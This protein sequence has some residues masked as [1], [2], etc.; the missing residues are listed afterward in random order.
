MTIAPTPTGPLLDAA[1]AILPEVVDLRRR[2]HR[3]PEVGLQ[4]PLTQAIVAGELRAMGLEPVL[5]RAVSSVVAAIEGS[6]PGPTIL[7]RADMDAL[8]LP[9]DTG[10][11]FASEHDGRMHACAHDTHMAMLLG[12]A[13][14]L[15]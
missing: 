8:P 3:I 13:R 2:L 6:R 1:H 5:G 10:L 7:L 9:E 14:L 15:L 11:P 12:A 4:L